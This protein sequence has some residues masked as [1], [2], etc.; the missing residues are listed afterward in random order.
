MIQPSCRRDRSR[1]AAEDRFDDF[2]WL[3]KQIQLCESV[4]DRVGAHLLCQTHI[5]SNEYP[6]ASS[7]ELSGCHAE[8]HSE[9]L[10]QR[11]HPPPDLCNR[12]SHCLAVHAPDEKQGHT[13]DHQPGAGAR[14]WIG[15]ASPEAPETRH[16]R[17]CRFIET[18]PAEG[19]W[20][21]H[22]VGKVP[23]QAPDNHRLPPRSRQSRA[24]KIP[25]CAARDGSEVG[26]GQWPRGRTRPA[27]ATSQHPR[28][29][30]VRP[31]PHRRALKPQPP[32][33]TPESGEAAG[34]RGIDHHH[35][36]VPLL[37]DPG[38]RAGNT[39]SSFTCSAAFRAGVRGD[40]A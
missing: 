22:A 7:A 35:C 31:L 15:A 8:L 16:R 4:L 11:L 38:G 28:A 40:R 23:Q 27:P 33:P 12:P 34:P 24:S 30:H 14:G 26:W 2:I 36:S 6:G 17:D 18:R 25:G 1:A 5:G 19:S 21:Y 13:K 32:H 29:G 20:L 3:A 10:P 39:P 9:D 37:P